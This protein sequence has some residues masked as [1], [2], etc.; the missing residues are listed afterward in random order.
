LGGRFVAIILNDGMYGTPGRNPKLYIPNPKECSTPVLLITQNPMYP[1]RI[2]PI[3]HQP[4]FRKPL[5]PPK[6]RI[7]IFITNHEY[8]STHHARS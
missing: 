2:T 7:N 8:R 1:P 4:I 5:Y 6:T 3:P